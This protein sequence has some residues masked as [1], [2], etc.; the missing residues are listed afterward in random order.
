MFASFHSFS[1]GGAKVRTAALRFGILESVVRRLRTTH[2]KSGFPI[3]RC[4]LLHHGRRDRA[5][6][7]GKES[8]VITYHDEASC[9]THGGVDLFRTLPCGKC[10]RHCMTSRSVVQRHSLF[11]APRVHIPR[12]KIVGKGDGNQLNVLEYIGNVAKT[13][14]PRSR[15]DAA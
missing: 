13:L 5:Q 11:S 15:R 2:R 8:C 10:L 12:L 1:Y 14:P 4:V 7:R 9:M 3:Q 6:C